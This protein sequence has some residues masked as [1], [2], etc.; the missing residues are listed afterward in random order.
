VEPRQSFGSVSPADWGEAV[1]IGGGPSLGGFDF[2][3]LRGRTV[4]AINDALLHVP[5]ATA[6]F[7]LDWNW[8]KNRRAEL[9]AYWGE[10]YLAPPEDVDAWNIPGAVYLRRNREPGLSDDPTTI[11]MGCNSG[12]AAINVAYLK[13]ARRIILLGYD[14]IGAHWHGGYAWGSGGARYYARWAALF[15][16]MLPQLRARGVEV[17]NASTIS[18]IKTFKQVTPDALFRPGG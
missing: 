15:D 6:F 7:T 14:M 3:R 18:R 9:L 2:N 10:V 5:W 11:R 8:I 13:G 4:L 12:Y 16:S 17:I 1:L